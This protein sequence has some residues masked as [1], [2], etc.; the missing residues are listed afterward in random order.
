MNKILLVILLLLSSCATQSALPPTRSAEQGDNLS[1]QF[2]WLYKKNFLEEITSTSKLVDTD[3]VRLLSNSNFENPT[4]AS[5][6]TFTGTSTAP[7]A[8]TVEVLD[9]LQSIEVASTAQNFELSQT[10]SVDKFDGSL[11][12]IKAWVKAD[13]AVDVCFMQGTDEGSCQP[14]DGTNQWQE[15]TAYGNVTTGTAIGIKFKSVG[16][17]TGTAYFDFVRTVVNPLVPTNIFASTEWVDNGPVV[18]EGSAQNPTKGTTV[19]DKL[20]W[21]RVGDSM[22]I[23]VQYSQNTS[24]NNGQG[25][26]R[27]KIPDGYEID[28]TK[29][30]LGFTYRNNC[31]SGAVLSSG[32][33][34]VLTTAFPTTSTAIGMWG[35]NEQNRV[36]I[37]AGNYGLG[38]ST[39]QYTFTCIV[40]IQGWSDTANGVVVQNRTDSSDVENVFSAR[41]ANNGTASITSE[42]SPFIESVNRTGPGII[43]Y[44]FK[45]GIFTVPPSVVPVVNE[46]SGQTLSVYNVT[47]TGFTT[48]SVTSNGQ[49]LIDTDVMLMVQKQGTDYIKE[50]DKVY[51][52]PVTNL[53]ENE[54]SAEIQNNGT[55]TIVSESSNFID[56]VNRTGPGQVVITFKSGFFSEPPSVTLGVKGIVAQAIARIDSIVTTTGFTVR[57]TDFTNS[58]DR[59]FYFQVQRQGSDY[60][61]PKGVYLGTFG[62]PT[63]IVSDVKPSGTSGGTSTTSPSARD[64]NTTEGNCT[65][66]SLSLNQFTLEKGVYIVEWRAPAREADRHKSALYDVTNMQ[67]VKMGSTA[68]TSSAASNTQTDS[69]GHHYLRVNSSTAYSI[70]HEVQTSLTTSGFGLESSSQLSITSEENYTTVKITKVR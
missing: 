18:I 15:V 33:T 10:V 17:V 20:Y 3:N 70:Y 37:A 52:V 69:I 44:V 40:P 35:L 19:L 38:N 65:F 12:G 68:H 49:S 24:G 63:C 46:N 36:N 7:V 27:F 47:N 61:E 39:V 4:V 43:N 29:T 53:V 42:S 45:S 58:T 55:A 51:T 28:D 11:V 25:L 8:E 31:G 64:L 9:G 5:G 66:L 13:H 30:G 1:V 54:F 32:Q 26:Y 57:T 2:S 23:K 14:Y 56:T 21:R 67:Y 41:I 16:N 22:E 34:Q 6:W 50:T 48:V 62:Q 60:I 59:D